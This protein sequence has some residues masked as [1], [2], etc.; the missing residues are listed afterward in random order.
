MPPRLCNMLHKSKVR[1]N[2]QQN[3]I[4]FFTHKYLLK[5]KLNVEKNSKCFYFLLIFGYISYEKLRYVL[6][7]LQYFQHT[8][9]LYKFET[10]LTYHLGML[11]NHYDF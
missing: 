3:Y 5:E 1:C 8:K 11:E 6:I 4:I 9:K 10:S 2:L 7:H